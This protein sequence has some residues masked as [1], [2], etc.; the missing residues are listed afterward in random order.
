MPT[1]EVTD[2][3]ELELLVGQDAYNLCTEDFLS[4]WD[5]LY[6]NCPWS[7]VFQS[8]NFVILWYR[9]YAQEYMPIIVIARQNG[10]L[11]GLL[12]L[13]LPLHSSPK[14]NSDNKRPLIMGAGMYEAEYQTWL[15]IPDTND[16]FIME[17]FRMIRNRFP[18]RDILLRFLPPSVPLDWTRT[19]ALWKRYVELQAV[20]RPI[21]KLQD[22]DVSKMFRKTE[23]RN[24]L[25]RLKRLG[26]L[27][28][29]RITDFEIFISILNELTVQYDFRQGAMFNMNQFRDNP[30]KS[31]FLLAMFEQD[32]LHVTVL[33]I[34]DEI[35][36]S[37]V[38]IKGGEWVHLAGINIHSPFYAS[39]SPGFVHFLLLGQQLAAEGTAMFDLTPGGDSY[40]ERM[41]NEH[42]TVHEL[43]VSSSLP[44]R[45]K[46]LAR[47]KLHELLI[48]AGKRPMSVE[49]SLRKKLY[50][51]KGRVIALKEADSLT[52]LRTLLRPRNKVDKTRIFR[53]QIGATPI[54]DQILVNRNN[55]QDL[56]N[57]EKNGGSLT[58]WEFLEYAMVR[59]ENGEH[60]YTWSENGLLL[61]CAWCCTAGTCKSDASIPADALVLHDI[62]YHPRAKSRLQDFIGAVAKRIAA[63]SSISL[64][65]VSN[66]YDRTL[67]RALEQTTSL[68]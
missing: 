11:I 65:I 53:I 60:S 2:T 31:K 48:K 15:A 46:R 8:S 39:A 27:K 10:H 34:E 52:T 22:P 18:N 32:L 3:C 64:Y 12:T 9:T 6:D 43:V 17:A 41:A 61:G 19:N 16:T 67:C 30:L 47:K 13:A 51:L 49:L 45:I 25:N 40:K 24:K 42:D 4:K 57:F 35:V 33:K 63:N 62:T 26:N 56:L 5:Q 66:A 29:E 68:L 37:I 55:L 59:F 23:F 54:S 7:T 36:G 1:P 20:S 50:L 14:S 28:F 44:Y 58:R 21:M 38:A